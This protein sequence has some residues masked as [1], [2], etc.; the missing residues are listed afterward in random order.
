MWDDRVLVIGIETNGQLREYQGAATTVQV[1]KSSDL[2]ENSAEVSIANINPSLAQDIVRDTSPWNSRKKERLL[3]VRAG[4]ATQGAAHIFT[5]DIVLAK[6]SAPPDRMLTMT[7]HTK[8]QGK[9]TFGSLQVSQLSL[10]SVATQIAEKWGLTLRYEAD[11]RMLES[12]SLNGT[13]KTALWRL[14]VEGKVDAYVDDE[15]LVVKPYGRALRGNSIVISADTG[16]ISMPVLDDKGVAVRML[17][18]PAI[19]IGQAITIK[20][21]IN[22]A[23]EGTYTLYRMICRLASRSADWYWDLYGNNQQIQDAIARRDGL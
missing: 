6:L 18:D 19:K 14:S 22:P 11:N 1:T 2:S 7:A 13:L 9:Y 8:D 12:F 21:A 23:A 5:G 16:M 17:F 15:N 3:T 20:S 4:R 10:Q